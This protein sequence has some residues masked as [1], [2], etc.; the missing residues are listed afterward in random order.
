MGW[1][2]YQN[3]AIAAARA[4]GT[5]AGSVGG[6]QTVIMSRA[7]W[8]LSFVGRSTGGASP[9]DKGAAHRLRRPADGT[10][11]CCDQIADSLLTVTA[12]ECVE[13]ALERAGLR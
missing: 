6:K 8:A 5:S 4:A 3:G 10:K 13:H 2:S 12:G 7:I 1:A 9:L 11:Y